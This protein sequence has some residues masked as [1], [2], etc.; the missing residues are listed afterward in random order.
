MRK[1]EGGIP[2]AES[3]EL[4]MSESLQLQVCRDSDILSS[5]LSAAVPYS[6]LQP[7]ILSWSPEPEI[8]WLAPEICSQHQMLMVY[9]ENGLRG[10]SVNIKP[11]P[12]LRPIFAP[13]HLRWTGNNQNGE[14][15]DLPPPGGLIGPGQAPPGPDDIMIHD[16]GALQD[17][18]DE[19][20]VPAPQGEGHN[21]GIGGDDAAMAFEAP[22][23][24]PVLTLYDP[25]CRSKRPILLLT[26]VLFTSI[27]FWAPHPSRAVN[28]W[29]K[30]SALGGI[31]ILAALPLPDA[32]IL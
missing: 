28:P 19:D 9:S 10:K 5:L 8:E 30:V 7:S 17:L 21:G 1:Q 22:L 24:G 2:A 6:Q 18:D 4:R 16:G 14:G 32:L 11:M 27:Q 3:K 26:Y 25:L 29:L 13:P 31:C 12:S 20:G 15:P 23:P